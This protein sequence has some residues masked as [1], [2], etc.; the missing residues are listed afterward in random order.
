MIT[1]A[2]IILILVGLSCIGFTIWEHKNLKQKDIDT[3]IYNQNL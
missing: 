2:Y 1:I 3:E